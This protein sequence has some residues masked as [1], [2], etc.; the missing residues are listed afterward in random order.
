M[1]AGNTKSGS[2]VMRASD[3]SAYNNGAYTAGTW[4]IMG[5]KASTL[6]N[7]DRDASVYV[8]IA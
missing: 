1:Y 3:C 6:Y 7:N 2:Y 4:R 8:R 5:M